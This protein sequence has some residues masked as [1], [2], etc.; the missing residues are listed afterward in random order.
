M[1]NIVVKP[2][3]YICKGD[4][5]TLQWLGQSGF[6]LKYRSTCIVLDP[7]IST[8]IERETAGDPTHKHTRITPPPIDPNS[9]DYADYIIC[10]HDHG[11]H[12]DPESILPI[13][14]SSKNCMLI[15]PAAAT[16]H[17]KSIGIDADK[18]IAME[19]E[20]SVMFADNIKISSIPCLH[21]RFGAANDF[22][23]TSD[24][25]YPNLG[26]I[27]DIGG[28]TIYHAGDTLY[29]AALPDILSEY[30]INAA[31]LPVNGGD[32]ERLSRGIIPNMQ[33]YEAADLGA[34]IA[35]WVVPVHY[36]MFEN[37]N[38]D[39]TLFTD[40]MD[41]EHSETPY[42]LPNVNKL[43]VVSSHP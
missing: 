19:G 14:R 20:D 6:L 34:K 43:L 29:Y 12:F 5:I 9:I 7:Y 33:Y 36:D 10:S 2:L 42:I 3:D 31:L 22:G 28:Y 41:E 32:S 24:Y 11:D 39:I 15:L 26:F 13:M 8:K 25:G 30:G 27:I 35:E 21:D 40:Y 1:I 18:I 23:Y 17:A 4:E 16:G 38:V 37:N